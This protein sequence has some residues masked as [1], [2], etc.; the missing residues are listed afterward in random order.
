MRGPHAHD[1]TI[2]E[3]AAATRMDIMSLT[4][5]ASALRGNDRRRL[6]LYLGS[7]IEQASH[8]DDGH[9]RIVV[10]EQRAIGVANLSTS[11]KVLRAIGHVPGEAYHMPRLCPASAQ[12]DDDIVERQPNLCRHFVGLERLG[13][14]IPANLPG[15]C[16]HAATRGHAVCVATGPRPTLR[17]DDLHLTCPAVREGG[18]SRRR[19][20]WS[21][22]VSVR[23]RA[24]T[25]SMHRGYL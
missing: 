13:G 21:L 20:R 5:A 15:D 9:R 10:T 12:D 3:P 19:K 1:T 7:R 4:P 25:N 22:P 17:L 11:R 8:N 16:D 2:A 23:G 24:G 14:R 6:D 18:A